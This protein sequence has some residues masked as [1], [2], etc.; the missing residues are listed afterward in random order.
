VAFRPCLAAGLAFS[1]KQ[2][3]KTTTQII[4]VNAVF[5]CLITLYRQK[6]EKAIGENLIFRF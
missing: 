4:D 3:T 2:Q 6:K 5:Y 1:D